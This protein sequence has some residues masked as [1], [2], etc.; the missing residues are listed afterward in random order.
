MQWLFPRVLR[1]QRITRKK[2][3]AQKKGKSGRR[4]L[5]PRRDVK[6]GTKL[7]SGPSPSPNDRRKKRHEPSWCRGHRFV[8]WVRI[9][10]SSKDVQ[11]SRQIQ[12][13]RVVGEWGNCI[14]ICAQFSSWHSYSHR[15][16]IKTACTVVAS[17]YL[18]ALTLFFS[19]IKAVMR[20]PCYTDLRAPVQTSALHSSAGSE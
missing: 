20:Q 2:P 10:I 9:S 12:H 17:T 13:R 14:W 18:P 15:Y 4:A 1:A 3:P 5:V 16:C 19:Q 6:V 7:L 8:G 11:S